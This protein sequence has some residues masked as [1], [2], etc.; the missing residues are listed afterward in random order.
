MATLFS[1]YVILSLKSEVTTASTFDESLFQPDH[2]FVFWHMS[3]VKYFKDVNTAKEYF[4]VNK[5]YILNIR[6]FNKNEEYYFWKTGGNFAGRLRKDTISPDGTNY[7]IDTQMVLRSVMVPAKIAK[8]NQKYFLKTRNYISD[9]S[10]GYNDS[11]FVEILS[12]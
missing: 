7:A 9:K 1:P 6:V 10:F 5:E 12:K 11:R 8:G 2:E 3:E 4:T